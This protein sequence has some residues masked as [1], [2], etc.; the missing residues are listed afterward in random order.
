MISLDLHQVEIHLLRVLLLHTSFIE[1]WYR[2]AQNVMTAHS[3]RLALLTVDWLLS[4]QSWKLSSL[5]IIFKPLCMLPMQFTWHFHC[6]LFTL[7]HRHPSWFE[8]NRL[9]KSQYVTFAGWPTLM[10]S[11]VIVH[12]R[13]SLMSS[14]LFV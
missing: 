1:D 9:V 14:F 10:C 6:I 5:Y 3:L 12:R 4:A 13:M 8:T 2:A 7:R 11:S